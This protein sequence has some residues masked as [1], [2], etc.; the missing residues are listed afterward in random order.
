MESPSRRGIWAEVL[1]LRPH[2]DLQASLIQELA[3]YLGYPEKEV[4]ERC[5]VGA[6]KLAGAW[7]AAAPQGAEEVFDFYRQTDAYLYDLTW[8]HALADDESVLSQVEALELARGY[9]ARTVLDFGSGIGSLG[10]LFAR[11]G[12]DVTLAEINPAL[13]DYARWRFDRR[14]L[15]ARF[16]DVGAEALPEAAFDFVS[17]VDVLEHVS[18]PRS[19]LIA[20]ATALRPGGT[21]FI[22]LPTEA[23]SSR[24][25][26]LWH[27]PDTI[28]R[29]L[30]EAGLWPAR[31]E[32]SVLVLRRGP[33]ARY[34]IKPNLKVQ[35]TK[36]GWVLLSERPLRAASLNPR[37]AEL[38]ERLERGC[39]A[40]ELSEE[41]D[42]PLTDV[43]AFLDNL[44]ERRIVTRMTQTL[45]VRWPAVTVVVPA[46][47]RPLETRAC[48]ES[49]LALDYPPDLLEV[50][51]VDDASP[52]PLSKVLFDLPV[53]VLRQ[54]TNEGQSAARNLASYIARGEVLAFTDNDCVADA[55]WLRSLVA[56]LCEPGTDM[57]GGHVLSPTSEGPVA[58]FE[59]TRSPLDMGVA[60]STVG[61]EEL[62]AYLP[63]C[64]LAADRETLRR[65]GGFDERMVLGEDADLVWRALRAGCG[66]RY[67]PAAKIL[68][69][70]RTRL[71]SLLRRRADYGSSE[72][73][74]QL[75]HPEARRVMMVPVVG[76]AVLAALT[77]LPVVWQVGLGLVVL[78][79]LALCVEVGV[80]LR[81]LR[82][83]GLRLPTRKI[84][85]AV[86]RQHGAGLYHLGANVARYYSLPLL[87]ASLLWL[88]LL[89]PVLLLL[90]IPPLVDHRRLRPKTTL[91]SFAFLYWSEMAAYQIGVWRG[92]LKWRTLRPLIPVLPLS[93][94][95]KTAG[96]SPS[97]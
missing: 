91:M 61:P 72:A 33:A 40:T 37:A 39:S 1:V 32:G 56:C 41:A 19:V 47:D 6:G 53:R 88:P 31:I 15:P 46:R 79:A 80:K 2:S 59:A 17:A 12:L 16:L 66:V 87:G 97:K 90:A 89:P 57:A 42:M 13:N 63:S 38:L 35:P 93:A 65:L 45:P 51:V 84:A 5:R 62:V 10:L 28:L 11:N 73:D 67:E 95:N 30:S 34:E 3:E 68:H 44:T 92:C 26:H 82:R 75:R 8:W 14:G 49:L 64:N 70:H 25:M 4:L 48:V 69:H 71:V 76:T 85:A 94:P 18:D 20:L 27:D 77:M 50:I 52:S 23:D 7:R 60:A 58:A 22:H 21:L 83:T 9:R 36:E 81:R 29:H 54:E 43:V 74:L 86:M 78:A 96:R 24:P 55:G